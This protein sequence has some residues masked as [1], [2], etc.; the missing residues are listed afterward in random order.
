M[1]VGVYTLVV[2][3]ASFGVTST[4]STIWGTSSKVIFT[5]SIAYNSSKKYPLGTCNGTM[6]SVSTGSGT[7][8]GFTITGQLK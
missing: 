1:S 2:G 5:G 3:S 4:S 8:T 7:L 6:T